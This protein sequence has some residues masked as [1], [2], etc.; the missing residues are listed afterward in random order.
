[1][2]GTTRIAAASA[3]ALMTLP[4]A[5][6]AGAQGFS[7]AGPFAFTNLIPITVSAGLMLTCGLSGTGSVDPWGN[8]AVTSV[9]FSPTASL[10]PSVTVTSLPVAVTG[11]ASAATVTLH[12]V[13]VNAITGRCL[14]NL[15]GSDD[16][17]FGIVTFTNASIASISG[18]AA[19][20]ISGR[21]RVTP[22]LH[23]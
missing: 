18:G 23:F 15:T 21:V 14:G 9:T 16:A 8:A 10:C 3:A 19:C 5:A 4:G 17:V 12:G 11:H 2:I 20:R 13:M 6:P 22:A 7:P 1:M